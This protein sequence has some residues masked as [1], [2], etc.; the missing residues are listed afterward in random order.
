MLRR[1]PSLIA[2]DLDGT[3]V[4]SAPDIAYAV[5]QMLLRLGLEPQGEERVRC[6]VGRGM[7]MLVRRAL[8][9]SLWPLE[10]PPQ[11]AEAQAIFMAIYQ[12]HLAE[13]TTLYEGA[14]PCLEALR[15]EAIPLALITN[16]P[17]RFTHA[18]VKAMGLEGFFEVIASGDDF[19]HQK[20]HPGPLLK[21]AD[22]LRVDP[23]K[24]LMV[25]DSQADAE[26]AR[27]AGFMLALVPYGYH[28]GEGVM[29]FE[30]DLLLETLEHL[31]GHLL[32]MSKGSP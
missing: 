23:D 16:K 30:P 25:G 5:D 31:P 9:G 21:T 4:D 6:W 13:R 18:L 17:A 19:A 27:R 24:S 15:V 7:A 20:P 1:R 2:F 32:S 22:R 3:L 29:R 28:G 26:A 10:D 11:M 8:T 14:L 12:E